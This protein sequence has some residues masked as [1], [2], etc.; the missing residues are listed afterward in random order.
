MATDTGDLTRNWAA[1]VLRGV[2]A[3]VF[4]LLVFLMPGLTLTALIVVFAAYAFVDGVLSL[5]AATRAQRGRPWWALVLL[6]VAGIGAAAIAIFWPALTA[7]TLMF[8]IAGWAIASG[9]LEIAAAIR[10]RRY[11]EGEWLLGLSGS[12]SILLGVVLLLQP[13]AGAV[14]VV[15]WIGAFAIL[16][17]IA[18]I[19]LALRLRK[20]AHEEG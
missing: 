16:T 6:G 7:L 2:V 9:V 12:L 5:I 11:I 18:Y 17:G 10:L 20:H 13:A 1:L 19:G 4:G 8:V 3:I 14:A 15:W